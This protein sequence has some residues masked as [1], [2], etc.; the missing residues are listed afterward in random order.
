MSARTFSHLLRPYGIKSQQIRIGSENNNGYA[1]TS[2]VDAWDRYIPSPEG[3]S[4][5]L[6]GLHADLSTSYDDFHPL[7]NHECRGS[8]LPLTDCKINRVEDVEDG[9]PSSGRDMPS[10]EDKSPNKGRREGRV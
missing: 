2:L 3:D 7:Q 6:Q 5:G 10:A 8:E 4:K 1:S 9:H